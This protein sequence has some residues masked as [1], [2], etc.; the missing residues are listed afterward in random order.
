[1]VRDLDIE[2]D[3]ESSPPTRATPPASRRGARGNGRRDRAGSSAGGPPASGAGTMSVG[4]TSSK[5]ASVTPAA[6]PTPPSTPQDPAA[7]LT[8]EDLVLKEQP[9]RQK[10]VGGRRNKRHGRSR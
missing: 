1:M 5:A 8:P 9:K 2:R 10:R 7:D 3:G 4:K 6:E